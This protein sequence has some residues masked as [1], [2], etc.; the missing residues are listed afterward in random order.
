MTQLTIFQP[1]Y[2]TRQSSLTPDR[3]RLGGRASA[4]GAIALSTLIGG[5]AL[6]E[7]PVRAPEAQTA[8]PPRETL[9]AFLSDEA[10]TALQSARQRVEAARAARTLWR[11]ALSKLAEAELAAVKRD[12]VATMRASLETVALCD[13]SQVQALSAPV[14]W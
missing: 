9:P 12:S 8:A 6:W 2:V 5:C 4:I 14:V 1:T 10:K 11:A 3:S 13:K 7:V